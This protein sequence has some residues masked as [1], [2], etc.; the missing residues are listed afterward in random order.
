MMSE[1]C[2][3]NVKKLTYIVIC[4]D[5]EYYFRTFNYSDDCCKYNTVFINTDKMILFLSEYV[6]SREITIFRLLVY[7][8][9]IK[10]D[11]ELVSSIIYLRIY[12]SNKNHED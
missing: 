5:N 4:N 8:N 6:T 10:D 9:S 1:C 3:K 11:L 2:Y 12:N 7:P